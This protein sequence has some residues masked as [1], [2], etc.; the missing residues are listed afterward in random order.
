MSWLDK[1][2]ETYDLN[3]GTGGLIPPFHTEFNAQVV[4]TLNEAGDFVDARMISE[5]KDR[6]TIIPCT[7]ESAARTSGRVA[8]PLFDSLMYVA[9][10]LADERLL[11]RLPEKDRSKRLRVFRECFELY[12]RQL[13]AWCASAYADGYVQTVLTYLSQRR[14]CEDLIK[15]SI[16]PVDENGAL[17]AEK[18]KEAANPA[19]A[20]LRARTAPIFSAVTGDLSKTVV[21]FEIERRN[22]PTVQLWKSPEVRT[23]WQNY[24]LAEA[25]KNAPR[26][27]CQTLGR[28]SPL[29]ELHPKRICNPG[30]NAKLISGNDTANFTY[31]GR[32]EKVLDASGISIEASQKA[33]SALRWLLAKQGCHEG[34]QYMVAWAVDPA[35][36]V[37]DPLKD[38]A[39]LLAD[40]P[41]NAMP[42]EAPIMP[43]TAEAAAAALNKLI[44]G[45]AAKLNAKGLCFMVIDAATPGTLAVKIFRDLEGSRYLENI[46]HWHSSCAWKQEFSKEKRFYGAP[47]PRDI[48]RAA[49]GEMKLDDPR[50]KSTVSRLLPCILDGAS[51]PRDIADCVIRRASHFEA[52]EPWE[53]RKNLAIACSIYRYNNQ[54]RRQY[55]M[56]LDPTISSRDY[57]YGRLL[58]VA[59]YLEYSALTANETSRPTNA[60]RLMARF[61]ERPYST[62]RN[63]SMA[64][65]PYKVR[66][67]ANRPGLMVKLESLL[68]EIHQLF[69]VADYENDRP[70]SGEYLLGYYCQK[71][72][73]FT[74]TKEASE[75]S[76]NN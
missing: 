50:L 35:P 19:E 64:L 69:T 15:K 30:D 23:A 56:S 65:T 39:D 71:Q 54:T 57:L 68:G 40:D 10:D 41:F 27:F 4:V 66:L 1:L 76:E 46:R 28:E 38:T 52:V 47:A 24:A 49:Y 2:V 43:D 72:D 74:K 75:D 31:R 44:A 6:A 16:L 9:G 7:E 55:T 58:A 14:L 8:H 67:T 25:G 5:K 18:P 32:F 29:A 36:E 70:L 33:H 63:L 45:Y 13:Q 62:W 61:A 21:L 11:A 60:V 48:V 17:F 51:I 34:S 3:V 73:F 59:D 22:L 37:P 53:F 42:D 26:G 12:I 20:E